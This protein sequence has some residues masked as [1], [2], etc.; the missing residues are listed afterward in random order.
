MS[1]ATTIPALLRAAAADAP[2]ADAFRYRDERLGYGDWVALSERLAG[3]LAARGVRRGDVVA[4]LLPSTPLYP[5]AY[6]A[7]ARLGAVTT[8][9][10]VRY[11]RTEIGHVLRQSG[12]KCLLGATAWHDADFRATVDSLNPELPELATI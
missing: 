12:A 7:A 1:P 6:M 11:R 2:Q 5:V 4:L 9:I 3:G 8:G 10:N